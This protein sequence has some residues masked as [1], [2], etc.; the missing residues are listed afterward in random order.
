MHSEPTTQPPRFG[1]LVLILVLDPLLA[2]LTATLTPI[3]KRCIE[4]LIDLPRRLAVTM[5]PLLLA[6][7]PTRTARTARR[8]PA[9]ER[10]R[11]TLGRTPRLLQLALELRNPS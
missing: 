7:P 5:P 11:L 10:G 9:R 8:V 4:F 6:R 1:Q 3:H 2:D